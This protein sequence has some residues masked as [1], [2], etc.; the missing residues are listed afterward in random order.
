MAT[1]R[2]EE[3][4]EQIVNQNSEIIQKFDELIHQ[5]WEVEQALHQVGGEVTTKLFNIEMNT[6]S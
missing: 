5:V 6:M 3:L 1:T 2:I 4:L